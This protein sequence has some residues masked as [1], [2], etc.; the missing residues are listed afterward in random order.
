MASVHEVSLGFKPKVL[1]VLY[2]EE[3]DAIRLVEQSGA[4]RGDILHVKEYGSHQ[5]DGKIIC[6]G[7]SAVSLYR[8]MG[9]GCIPPGY[10]YVGDEFTATHWIN[11]ID[12][13]SIIWIDVDKYGE[14]IIQN[15][16]RVSIS[17]FDGELGRFIILFKG[18]KAFDQFKERF[19]SG[20]QV[21]FHAKY[22]NS[23]STPYRIFYILQ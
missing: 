21:P 7:T 3:E 13:N 1:D 19:R 14:S 23:S 9:N 16:D 22:I 10:F 8:G 12:C 11:A 6:T 4:K 5:N 20:Q 2:M 15:Y 17:H 18:D